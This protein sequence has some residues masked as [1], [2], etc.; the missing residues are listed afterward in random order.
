MRNT[1]DFVIG[2]FERVAIFSRPIHVWEFELVVGMA[3]ND[4]DL[5]VGLENVA[6]S[7][8]ATLTIC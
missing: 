4:D 3:L 1:F 8:C 7:N 5:I 2:G 6:E